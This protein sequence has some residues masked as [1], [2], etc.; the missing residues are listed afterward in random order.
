MKLG[1][2][3]LEVLENYL[4]NLQPTE[5]AKFDMSF[6]YMPRGCGFA[7][8]ALG[9]AANIP[10]FVTQGLHIV[11][12]EVAYKDKPRALYAAEKFFELTFKE[13][14]HLFFAY[15]RDRRLA[16]VSTLE[17]ADRIKKLRMKSKLGR[18]I[19]NMWGR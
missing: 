14:S 19:W 8:C 3:R 5:H 7:G 16:D 15:G 12:G 6:W 4:R 11:D 13:A 18:W 17:V 9:H 10:E 2:Q 1:N